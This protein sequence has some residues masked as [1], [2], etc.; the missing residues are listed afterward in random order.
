MPPPP[1]CLLFF[2]TGSVQLKNS[3]TERKCALRDRDAQSGW[4][5]KEVR[6]VLSVGLG[7][8]RFNSVNPKR[9]GIWGF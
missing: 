5:E 9:G 4:L 3:R 1:G 6:I 7:T 8:D 2:K